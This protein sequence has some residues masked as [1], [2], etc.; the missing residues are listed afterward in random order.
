MACPSLNFS[1]QEMMIMGNEKMDRAI[2]E[3]RMSKSLFILISYSN[4]IHQ[5]LILG[6]FI[7]VIQ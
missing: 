2:K 3:N 6:G 1:K 7:T 4:S 5:K